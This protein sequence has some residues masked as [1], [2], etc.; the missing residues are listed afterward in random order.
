M[1]IYICICIYVC[2]CVCVYVYMVCVCFVY[3]GLTR[4]SHE[5]LTYLA[6]LAGEVLRGQVG[7]G[8]RAGKR[9]D[10]LDVGLVWSRCEADCWKTMKRSENWSLNS[11]S[12]WN[13]FKNNQLWSLNVS[14]DSPR[15]A[16]QRSISAV[17]G[18]WMVCSPSA[19]SHSSSSSE[20]SM[21]LRLLADTAF[22]FGSSKVG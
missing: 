14:N 2:V 20:S 17:T 19:G 9:E 5:G 13:S 21:S 22:A 11:Q 4:A 7:V 6:V 8:Q 1:Y 16:F 15:T 3:S 12:S 10:L 18:S